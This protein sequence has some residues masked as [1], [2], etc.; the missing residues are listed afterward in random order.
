MLPLDATAWTIVA[1]CALLV[2]LSKTGLPG[3]GVLAVPLVA[4]VVPAR[5]STGFLLPLLVAADILAIV[6]W[7][8]NVD[9]PKLGRLLPWTVAGIVAGYF[10]LRF[11]SNQGLMPVIGLIVL[12]MIGLTRWRTSRSGKCWQ[13]PTSLWF[14]AAVGMLAGCTSMMANA[15]GPIMVVYMLAMRMEK[16]ELI[17]T[18]AWFFW[19]VNI[20]KLPFSGSLDL[21]TLE[22][23]AT[24]LALLPCIAAGGIAGIF[25]VHRIPQ[26]LFNRIIEVVA[27]G[28]AL[29]LCVSPLF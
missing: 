1:F 28:T 2:G 11:I 5:E 16:K 19:I 20:S 24:D 26:E 21:I 23:L 6:Y 3:A 9:W 8:R 4:C 22:S 12:A 27:A 10:G 15:A 18:M 25:L 29:Y 14:A 7:R 17:G 13:V